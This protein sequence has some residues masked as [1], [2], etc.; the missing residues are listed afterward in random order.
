MSADQRVA[1]AR[2]A[3]ERNFRIHTAVCQRACAHARLNSIYLY[4]CLAFYTESILVYDSLSNDSPRDS[5]STVIQVIHESL[6]VI[7]PI[8]PNV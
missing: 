4:C 6:I 1:A 3:H 8:T 7:P 5:E 2:R